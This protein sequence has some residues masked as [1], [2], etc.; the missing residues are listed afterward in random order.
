MDGVL[1]FRLAGVALARPLE[2]VVRPRGR[3]RGVS[4]TSTSSCSTADSA[5]DSTESITSSSSVSPLLLLRCLDTLCLMSSR[6][7]L[8]IHVTD[9]SYILFWNHTQTV[10]H[11][12]VNLYLCSNCG[13]LITE[14]HVMVTPD[15]DHDKFVVRQFEQQ[16][17]KFLQERILLPSCCLQFC[18]RNYKA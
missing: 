14:E 9:V 8:K 18:G 6:T 4:S 3:P 12:I 5:A 7:F 1:L 17:M 10:I 16:T 11:P 15:P 13:E 2:L